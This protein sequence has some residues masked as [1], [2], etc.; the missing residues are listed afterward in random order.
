MAAMRKSGMPGAD[1]GLVDV[2]AHFVTAEYVQAAVS[3]GITTPDGMPAWPSWSAE[4]HLR[5]MDEN[6]IE[7][8]YLS[9][10][11]PGTHFGDDAAAAA[12]SRQVNEFG[13]AVAA[14]RPERFGHFASLPLPNVEGA[15]RE[16]AHALDVLGS[17]GVILESNAHGLYLGDERMRPLLAELDRRRAIVFVHPT[18]PPNH[19]QVSI[20][21]PRPMV[22]FMFDSTRTLAD[23]VF[24]GRL[25]EFGGIRWVFSHSGA[26]MPVLADRIEL[27]RTLFLAEQ[28]GFGPEAPT[29]PELLRE[30][31]F[32]IAGTPFPNQVPA[33]TRAFGTEHLLYGS[34]YCYTPAR[35]VTA[36][37]ATIDAAEPPAPGDDWRALTTR[38]AARLFAGTPAASHH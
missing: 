16:L 9:V 8:S 24:S 14:A 32:D 6:G 2:H 25:T 38:N 7:K 20:G 4:D 28:P 35:G 11:S 29:V 18:S 36:Q 12:L 22:E 30:L 19:E 1:A 26:A 3:A 10:S 5:L 15:L 23:L 33:L 34:D 31:W 21:R 17:D 27:F 13:A 37:L